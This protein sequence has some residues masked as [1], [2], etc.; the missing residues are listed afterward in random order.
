MFPKQYTEGRSLRAIPDGGGVRPEAQYRT[1][2]E[3]SQG[4]ARTRNPQKRVRVRPDRNPLKLIR[5]VQRV[6]QTWQQPLKL[7]LP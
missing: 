3:S 2:E 7:I 4:Y 6:S 1:G 5:N